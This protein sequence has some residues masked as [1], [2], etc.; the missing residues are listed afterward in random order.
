MPQLEA[1]S[2]QTSSRVEFVTEFLRSDPFQTGHPN[3][4]SENESV[5]E[6]V[7]WMKRIRLCKKVAL[8]TAS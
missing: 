1:G 6:A 4:A 3:L 8:V 5:E 2:H 7:L